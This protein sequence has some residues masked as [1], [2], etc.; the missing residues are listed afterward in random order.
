MQR[1][2]KD[3]SGE[4]EQHEY[5]EH[6]PEERTGIRY[7]HVHAVRAVCTGLVLLQ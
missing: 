2:G 7:I 5:R 4:K 3:V 6:R 1:K